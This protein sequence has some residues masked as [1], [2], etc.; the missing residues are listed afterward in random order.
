MIEDAR[1]AFE[2]LALP[3]NSFTLNM[4]IDIE[5]LLRKQSAAMTWIRRRLTLHLENALHIS[6]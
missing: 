3:L 5:S 6:G 1:R 4:N 2:Q